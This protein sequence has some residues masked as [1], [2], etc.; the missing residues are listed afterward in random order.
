VWQDEQRKIDKSWFSQITFHAFY[1]KNPA[2]LGYA[3]RLT[4]VDRI[5]SGAP[6]FLI[7]CQAKD[8]NADP[9]E[10]ATFNH[11]EVFVGGRLVEI[12]GDSWLE[13]TG[14]R[15]VGMVRPAERSTVCVRDF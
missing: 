3:E 13:W 6:S 4:H 1:K 2:N 7:M 5:R 11:G 12:A 15:S 10:V 9:R 14:R 8:V